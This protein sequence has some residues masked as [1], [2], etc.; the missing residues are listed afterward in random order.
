M[1]RSFKLNSILVQDTPHSDI[2]TTGQLDKIG[3]KESN[4]IWS[5][6]ILIKLELTI[7]IDLLEYGQTI[8]KQKNLWETITLLQG[9]LKSKQLKTM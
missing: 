4:A 7:I 8:S 5:I 1:S 9:M 3:F 2:L 6:Q